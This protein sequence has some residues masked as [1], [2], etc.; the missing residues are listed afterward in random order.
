MQLVVHWGSTSRGTGAAQR[1]G[2][3]AQ[4]STRSYRFGDP[5]SRGYVA[6]LDS[7]LCRG[8]CL[9]ACA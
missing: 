2:G 3:L 5:S 4:P 6:I 9:E 8:H 7:C 1:I